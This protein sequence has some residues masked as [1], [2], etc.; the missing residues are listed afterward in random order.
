MI[1]WPLAILIGSAFGENVSSAISFGILEYPM[2]PDFEQI[3]KAFFLVLFLSGILVVQ[4][5]R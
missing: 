1:L 2:I 5:D 3:G 4:I